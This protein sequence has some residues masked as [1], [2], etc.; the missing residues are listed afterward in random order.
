MKGRDW[1]GLKRKGAKLM[2]N[3]THFTL[4]EL[5]QYTTHELA[6][7][8]DQAYALLNQVPQHSVEHVRLMAAI[9]TITWA[10]ALK[11]GKVVSKPTAEM[12]L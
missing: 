4:A 2:T 5:D 8:L 7:L 6:N 9:R 12:T 3:F 1:L 10:M 11:I